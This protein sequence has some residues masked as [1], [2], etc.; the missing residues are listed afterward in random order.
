V[1]EAFCLAGGPCGRCR[2][3]RRTLGLMPGAGVING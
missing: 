2:L 3:R 1:A